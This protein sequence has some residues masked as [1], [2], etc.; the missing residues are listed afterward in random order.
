M[1]WACSECQTCSDRKRNTGSLCPWRWA[2][3]WWWMVYWREF[4]AFPSL[5]WLLLSFLFESSLTCWAAWL[6]HK[7]LSPCL[8]PR[9]PT[10]TSLPLSTCRTQSHLCMLRHLQPSSLPYQYLNP[11]RLNYCREDW[12]SCW[13]P[14]H[15]YSK[16]VTWADNSCIFIKLIPFS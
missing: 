5:S 14:G 8:V 4:W 13:F 10:Q 3:I 7:D 15:L 2:A 9:K 6:Q 16:L 12:Y 11:L 1:W